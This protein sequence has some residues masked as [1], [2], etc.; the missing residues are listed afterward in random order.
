MYDERLYR[1][2]GRFSAAGLAIGFVATSIIGSALAFIY[3][4]ALRYIPFIYINALLTLGFGF[5]LGLIAVRFVGQYKIRNTKMACLMTF[6]A[7]LVA[8]YCAWVVWMVGHLRS[9]DIEVSMFAVAR[10]PLVVC[11]WILLFNENGT[12]SIGRDGTEPVKGLFL[13]IIW[14]I[15]AVMIFGAALVPVIGRLVT[16]FCEG[17]QTWCEERKGIAA[18]SA[19]ALDSLRERVM[20]KDWTSLEEAG[21]DRPHLGTWC[22]LDLYSCP[23]CGQTNTLTLNSLTMTP[24]KKGEPK[25]ESKT[26]IDRLLLTADESRV[27]LEACDRLNARSASD[28]AVAAQTDAN[29]VSQQATEAS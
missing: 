22:A 29:P 24:N 7:V 9:A 26:V 11:K 21:P 6:L 5:V 8:Y 13:A 28:E 14:I 15:E 12:W 18:V 2:S 10:H 17:C 20:G 19:A 4:Y 27:L 1:H 23:S 25:T 16:P 3:A